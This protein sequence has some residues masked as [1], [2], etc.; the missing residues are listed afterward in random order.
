MVLLAAM[1]ARAEPRSI[2]A[3]GRRS[4]VPFCS[5]RSCENGE[6]S[7]RLQ[8]EWRARSVA[9]TQKSRGMIDLLRL[10]EEKD[11]RHSSPTHFGVQPRSSQQHLQGAVKVSQR[12]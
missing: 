4:K 1:A 2:E 3:G 6:Y 7:C 10:H 5:G 11:Q 12:T 8:L 9:T